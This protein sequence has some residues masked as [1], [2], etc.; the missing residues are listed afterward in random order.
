MFLDTQIHGNVVL[1]PFTK[2][3]IFFYI[4]E[5]WRK[6]ENVKT[7]YI[8]KSNEKLNGKNQFEET[9]LII[10]VGSMM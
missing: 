9:V 4:E 10:L 7:K 3:S 5:E 6:R 8:M 1:C 2:E